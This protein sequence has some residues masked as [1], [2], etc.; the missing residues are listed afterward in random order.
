MCA[1]PLRNHRS[2]V[3]PPVGEQQ[4]AGGVEVAREES[5]ERRRDVPRTRGEVD[6]RR[7]RV[8]PGEAFEEHGHPG[9]GDSGVLVEHERVPEGEQRPGQSGDHDGVVDVGDDAEVDIGPDDADRRLGDHRPLGV[10]PGLMPARRQGDRDAG[11]DDAPAVGEDFD[12]GAADLDDHRDIA[13]RNAREA[14][15]AANA[16][17]AA[18]PATLGWLVGRDGAAQQYSAEDAHPFGRSVPGVRN[19]GRDVAASACPA[20]PDVVDPVLD[21]RST[22]SYLVIRGIRSGWGCSPAFTQSV[23]SARRVA[24]PRGGRTPAAPPS[25]MKPQTEEV[26]CPM[27]T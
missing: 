18:S 8:R 27:S 25:R 13:D 12:A 4:R 1:R 10:Q 22:V 6:D 15:P 16:L 9:C 19:D 11:V 14:A 24:K 26:S 20:F 7:A 3:G 17:L 2:C 23:M 21:A 5:R